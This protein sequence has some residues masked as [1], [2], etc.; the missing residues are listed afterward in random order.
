MG[1]IPGYSQPDFTAYTAGNPV[2]PRGGSG[3][4]DRGAVWAATVTVVNDTFYL[5]YNGTINFSTQPSQIGLAT[6]TDG[7]TFTKSPNNPILSRDG[8]GFDSYSVVNGPLLYDSGSWYLYYGG[9]SSQPN[10]PSP[11]NIISRATA[12]NPHGPWIRT[13]DTLMTTGSNGEWDDRFI[14]PTQ[15]HSTYSGLVMYYW[16]SDDWY[17]YTFKCQIGMAISVD[18]GVSW[19]KYDDP[20]TT[21]PPYAESDPIVKIGPESWDSSGI[22]GVGVVNN[23]AQWEMY[24][25]GISSMTGSSICYATSPDEI[26]WQKDPNNPIYTFWDDPL[27]SMIQS[28]AVTMVD[29]TYF[30]YYDYG[31][32]SNSAGIG[33]ATYPPVVGIEQSFKNKASNFILYQNYPNPFNACTNIEFQIPKSE[34]VTLKIYNLLGEEVCTLFSASL[35]SGFHSYKFDASNLPGGVYLYQLKAGEF[36]QTRKSL[37]LK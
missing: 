10:F 22:F 8:S 19:Q 25:N 18:G 9:I 27:A 29:S 21:S 37:L 28:S 2:V 35:L 11:G 1:N 7:Y 13:D 17:P 24:Y 33:L 6:S 15:I 31:F 20:A 26:V 3:T 4:W 32:S 12:T 23:G 16:A 34:F 14:C 5:I 30:L 36:I